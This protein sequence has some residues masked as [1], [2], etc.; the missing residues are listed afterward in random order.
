MKGE[1]KHITIAKVVSRSFIGDF[2]ST[3]QNFL[4]K[5]LTQYQKMIDKGMK[6]IKDEINQKRI[7]VD[8][9]RY[10]ISQLTNGAMAIVFYGDK[11]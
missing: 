9:Y 3:I 1:N 2:I 6:Q 5:N 4:G 10:E 8:W 7:K 11:K